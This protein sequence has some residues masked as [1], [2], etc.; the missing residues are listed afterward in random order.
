MQRRIKGKARFTYT[1]DTGAKIE[2]DGEDYQEFSDSDRVDEEGQREDEYTQQSS[3]GSRD[4]LVELMSNKEVIDISS[5]LIAKL[6][7]VSYDET[8]RGVFRTPWGN[9]LFHTTVR[10]LSE[11]ME[12]FNIDEWYY[13]I[14][15]H[16]F[17]QEAIGEFKISPGLETKTIETNWLLEL[18]KLEQKAPGFM[19]ILHNALDLEDKTYKKLGTAARDEAKYD[20]FNEGPR[21]PALYGSQLLLGSSGGSGGPGGRK[22]TGLLIKGSSEKKEAPEAPK[23]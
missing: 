5:T 11:K 10:R 17:A 21:N 3:G 15:K 1:D 4:P 14:S 22:P 20:W 19:K 23:K 12:K 18:F 13:K 2:E 6:E 7:H 16:A 8:R 9:E